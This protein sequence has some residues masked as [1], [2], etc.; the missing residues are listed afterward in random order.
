MNPQMGVAVNRHLETVADGLEPWSSGV[1]YANF[2]DVPIDT[3]TCYSPEA[4][5]RLQAVK[6]RYDVDDLFRANHPIPAAAPAG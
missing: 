4:F 1:N 2:V 3:R 5:D 6:A